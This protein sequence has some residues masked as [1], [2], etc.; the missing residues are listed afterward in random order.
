MSLLQLENAG[1]YYREN[2]WVFR[3]VNLDLAAGQTLSILGRN[4]A[5]KSTLLQV[6]LGLLPPAEG[7]ARLDG[8]ATTHL[9]AAKRARLACYLPQAENV[10]VAYSVTDYL[11]MGRTPYLGGLQLAQE[12]RPGSRARS[13]SRNGAGQLCGPS[14][15]RTFRRRKAAHRLRTR[16]STGLPTGGYGRAPPEIGRA[17]CRERV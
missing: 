14:H 5:G 16:T 10:S 8:A 9:S 7:E 1:F 6:A 17:S 11:L 3:D 13:D 12:K 4:G 2:E 15:Q